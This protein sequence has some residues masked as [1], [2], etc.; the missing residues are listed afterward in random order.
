MRI[1]K[2]LLVVLIITLGNS[3]A[4][5]QTLKDAVEQALASNPLIMLNRAQTLSAKSDIKVAKGSL[6]PSIDMNSAYGNEWTSSPF[7]I[8][9]AGDV[10]NTLWRREFSV[11]MTQNIYSAGAIIEGINKNV[12]IYKAKNYKTWEAI[13]EISLGVAV[14]YMDVLL[15]SKLVE[16]AETNLA[17]H[18][19]LVNLIRQRGEAGV[20]RYAELDQGESR[21]ALADSNL[22]NAKGNEREARVRFRKIVGDWPNDLENPVLPTDDAFPKDLDVAV[23]EAFNNHPIVRSANE[24]IKQA[25][26]QRKISKAAFYPQFDA[27][28]TI[29]RN[30]NLDGVPGNNEENV[31]LIRMKYNL[32]KGGSDLGRLRKSS[33]QVQEAFEERDRSMIDV[34]ERVQLEYNTWEASRKRTV[35]L[36]DYIRSIE[37][38]RMS[39]FEQFKIG[40][41][42][43]LDL[44]NSQNEVYRSKNDYL[45]ASR[46]EIN[47]RYKILNSIG[48]LVSFFAQQK[49]DDL[50]RTPVFE[51]PKAKKSVADFN[52]DVTVTSTESKQRAAV[53]FDSQEKSVAA[54]DSGEKL[55]TPSGSIA[56]PKIKVDLQD[57]FAAKDAENTSVLPVV[58]DLNTEPKQADIDVRY[59]VELSGFKNAGLSKQMSKVLVRKGYRAIA[60]VDNEADLNMSHVLVGPYKTEVEAHEA[61]EKI[62]KTNKVIGIVRKVTPKD[63]Y[64]KTK[65][66]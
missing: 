33:Y 19:R 11:S 39:Y 32:F 50:Y 61:L 37:K 13:N 21:L 51:L 4:F 43:F 29:S 66:E 3:V 9:L 12:S 25:I 41:R 55:F 10:S 47:A 58:S 15:R 14:A 18:E 38:T 7:T 16:I 8:D 24:G 5:A 30:R 56:L 45:Q 40:Q 2:V 44:L 20:A 64:S 52:K 48:R 23:R 17:E 1:L 65:A 54:V 34:R 6:Y 26:A 46:D 42:T 62:V 63:P 35:V 59:V 60:F 27:V 36:S 53:T 57:D 49:G 22:I 28:F 31:S